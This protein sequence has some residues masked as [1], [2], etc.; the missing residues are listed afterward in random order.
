MLD[1]DSGIAPSLS[2]SGSGRVLAVASLASPVVELVDAENGEVLADFSA[3]DDVSD[4]RFS[5]DTR[6]A[7][8]TIQG[9]VEIWN[10][11]RAGG[12]AQRLTG[13]GDQVGSV[14]FSPDGQ[15]LASASG[16]ATIALWDLTGGSFRDVVGRHRDLVSEARFGKA[17]SIVVTAAFDGTIRVW[18]TVRGKQLHELTAD[19]DLVDGLAITP[20]GE[21]ALAAAGGTD[22]TMWSVADGRSLGR[23]T[24]HEEAVEEV[25]VSPQGDL[26]ASVDDSGVCCS[27]DPRTRRTVGKAIS[28][29]A[30][31]DPGLT[32]RTAALLRPSE[33]T[34][35]FVCG[36]WSA[37]SCWRG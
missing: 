30:A 14:A 6:L 19:A 27:R 3:G 10:T 28:I 13:H 32:V 25:A 12:P 11:T 7:V 35:R 37:G 17:D 9:T 16:D 18:D 2:Y 34:A 36:T 22:V 15:T 8:A 23:F 24:E 5:L 33:A 20:D 26:A 29:P 1:I 4:L 31:S 21:T